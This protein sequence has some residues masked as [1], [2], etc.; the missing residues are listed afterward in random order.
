MKSR[1]EKVYSKLPKTELAKVELAESVKKLL[2]YT[3]GILVFSKNIEIINNEIKKSKKSLE[4]DL[5][6]L[7]SDMGKVAKGI[8]SAE[9]SAKLLGIKTN[10]IPGYSKAIEA[11]KVGFGFEKL[12]KQILKK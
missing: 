6:D 9:V 12:A 8:E 5:S 2:S 1:L 4:A 3:K 10:D 11:I 7:Q